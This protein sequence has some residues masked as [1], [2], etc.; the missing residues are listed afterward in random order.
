MN[1][2]RKDVSHARQHATPWENPARRPNFYAQFLPPEQQEALAEAAGAD[3]LG[4]EIAFLRVKARVLIRAMEVLA[5][6]IRIDA[7]M[8]YSR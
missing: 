4:A 2:T 1:T 6:L 5:R 8:R 7:R 3:G